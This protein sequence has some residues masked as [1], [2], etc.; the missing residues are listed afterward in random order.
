MKQVIEPVNTTR[1][2]RHCLSERFCSTW[3]ALQALDLHSKFLE[4]FYMASCTLWQVFVEFYSIMS[5]LVE[6][7]PILL[8]RKKV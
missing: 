7:Y 1:K 2:G 6:K 4:Y 8:I 3:G 5:K